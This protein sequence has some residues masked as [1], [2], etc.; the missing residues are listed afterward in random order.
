MS[1]LD[2]N[3]QLKRFDDNSVQN[4]N[5]FKIAVTFCHRLHYQNIKNKL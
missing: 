3:Q 5:T 2:V 4:K 1:V